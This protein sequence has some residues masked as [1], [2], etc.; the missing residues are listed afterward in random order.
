MIRRSA[1]RA[2]AA[3]CAALLTAPLTACAPR[4]APLDLPPPAALT[5]CA[6]SSA[7]GVPLQLRELRL[8]LADDLTA[9]QR[10]RLLQATSDALDLLALRPALVTERRGPW[11][12]PL[13]RTAAELEA[14]PEGA[15]L[16]ALTAPLRTLAA[17]VA[18]LGRDAL[19][20][21][22]FSPLVR[23]DSLFASMLPELEGL[24][25]AAPIDGYDEDAHGWLPPDVAHLV[26]LDATRL[27]RH[28]AA[29]AALL[30][31]HEVGH[32]FGLDH[33]AAPNGVM[34]AHR[35]IGAGS[36]QLPATPC[37]AP[38]APSQRATVRAQLGAGAR[39]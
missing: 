10:A 2:A 28:D 5:R 3:L 19:T 25:L 8:V 30:V 18:A 4:P 31:A 20:I 17:D 24:G 11:R 22:A 27:T 36:K 26:L 21:V 38:L 13:L 15:R 16:Q 7:A 37:V 39:R 1:R 33:D 34:A 12:S 35:A 23:P 32:A 29:G 6:A 9:D 14:V